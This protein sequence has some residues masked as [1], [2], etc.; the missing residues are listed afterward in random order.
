MIVGI[1]HIALSALDMN[2]ALKRLLKWGYTPKFTERDV[3]NHPAKKKFLSSVMPFHD[4]AYCQP[5]SLG[6]A[7][8]L[9]V[10]G[11]RFSGEE[12]PYKAVFS[13]GCPGEI[14]K[15]PFAH[16]SILEEAF[17]QTPHF[18]RLQAFQIDGYYL[19]TSDE[20]AAA[21]VRA[22]VL[23]CS[24]LVSSQR[25]WTRLG[26]SVCHGKQNWI[27]LQFISPIEKWQMELLLIH[28]KPRQALRHRIDSRGFGCLAFLTTD[29]DSD[30]KSLGMPSSDIFDLSVNG[31]SMKICLCEGL[32]GETIELIQL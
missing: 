18:V 32:D 3:E 7:I 4:L 13:G 8:E 31:K 25:F 29:I 24:D 27:K 23:E 1:D 10:H 26:F 12:A 17:G 14:I 5:R 2:Q 9:T 22:F 11:R 16:Q 19:G 15:P 6:L 28:R 30:R 21:N 20:R